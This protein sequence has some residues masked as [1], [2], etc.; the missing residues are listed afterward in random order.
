[1]S[2]DVKPH[3]GL[4][5]IDLDGVCVQYTEG[6]REFAAKELGVAPEVLLDPVSYSFH[7]SGWF[8]SE[9][10]FREVH[11]KAVDA[12]LYATLEEI[13]GASAA[14]WKLN[15]LGFHLRVITSRFVNHGQHLR[16]VQDTVASLDRL[17]IP[18]RDISFARDKRDFA[19]DLMIDDSPGNV[20]SLRGIGRDVLVFEAPYNLHVPGPRARNWDEVVEY[21]LAKFPEEDA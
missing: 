14:L 7:E 13:P 10:H 3:R 19:C 17:N 5:G 21:V 18:Y 2:T 12:G 20:E 15:D 16:V 4:L 6:L 9:E 11:G 8:E 1:M